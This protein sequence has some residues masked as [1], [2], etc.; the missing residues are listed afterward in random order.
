MK[1]LH[2]RAHA[3]IWL[4]L[5]PALLFAIYWADSGRL[6]PPPAVDTS[7]ASSAGVLP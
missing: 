6:T 5:L 1:R 4:L 3:L 7:D 2:R